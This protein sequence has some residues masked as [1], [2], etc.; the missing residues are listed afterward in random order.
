MKQLSLDSIRLAGVRLV[1]GTILLLSVAALAG[2]LLRGA[3]NMPAAVALS[4][5]L[6]VYP[7]A[8]L[9]ARRTDVVA[10]ITLAVT[11][12]AMPALLLFVF[13]G[14]AWQVDLHMA[15]FAALAITACLCD[16]RALLAATATVAVHH[17]VVGMLV[18][19]WV[20]L[21]GGGLMRILVHAGILIAEAGAL[22]LLA[23]QLVALLEQVETQQAERL[24]VEAASTRDREARTQE[25]E[26]V[27]ALLG[28]NLETIARGDLSHDIEQAVPALYQSLK[29]HYNGAVTSLRGL[30]GAVGGSAAAIRTGSREIANASEDLARRTEANAASLGRTNESVQA[31]NDRLLNLAAAAEQTV[32]RADKAIAA[33]DLGRSAADGVMGAM[34]RVAD[35]AKGI[36]DVIEG[37]DKIAFQTRVLA[38]NAAVEAGRAGEAGRGFAVVADLVSSLAMRAEE[39]AKRARKQLTS[40]QADIADAV[41]T[42]T[43]VDRALSEIATDVAQVHTLLREVAA[44]NA[45]QSAVI[46]EITGAIATMDRAFQQ[47]AAMVEETSAAARNLTEE[48]DSLADQA[49]R[50]AVDTAAPRA[51]RH[52]AVGAAT[53]H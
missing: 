44:E 46:G 11:A 43:Q 24:A 38:M 35:S 40:T 41:D 28:K 20:F 31:M 53:V 25:A 12:A 16:W 34:S 1:T 27:I 42:A 17:L 4:L 47:N 23:Q 29:D 45:G 21:N 51:G 18:P 22:I 13:R 36:D 5:L 37:L 7:C 15:F 3:P 49:A 10:R 30:I 19:E 9:I 32:A 2:A 52:P 48:V 26:G 6:P 8:L 33:V 39:E 50:F 14:A